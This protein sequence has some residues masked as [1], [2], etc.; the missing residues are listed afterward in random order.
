MKA[1]SKILAPKLFHE[2]TNYKAYEY[3]GAHREGKEYVFRVW[4]PNA[5][6]AFVTGLFNGWSEDDPMTRVDDKGIWEARIA[7]NRFGSGYAYEYKFKSPYGEVYKCDP[8]AFYSETY[9]KFSSRYFD[10]SGYKWKDAG[11]MKKRGER[12]TRERVMNSPMNIYEVH[13]ESWRKHPNGTFPSYTELA[14]E[15]APYVVQMGYTHISLMPICEYYS[16]GAIAYDT[17][18]YF[19]PT[20]RFGTPKDFMSFVDTMHNA[21]IGVILEWNC[22]FLPEE[23]H[24]ISKFDGGYV[25]EYDASKDK[26]DKSSGSCFNI[27]SPEVQSFLISGAVYWTSVYHIDG[28]KFDDISSMLSLD[29]SQEEILIDPNI[30]YGDRAPYEAAAFFRKLNRAMIAH[31][32]DV[33]MIAEDSEGK[34]EVTDFKNNGLGFSL[35]W[36]KLWADSVISYASLSPEWRG[37]AHDKITR[38]VHSSYAQRNIIPLSHMRV[39]FGNQSLVSKLPGSYDEKFAQ[40]RAFM[41]YFMTQPGKKLSFMG[42]EISQFD[43]WNPLGNIQWFLLDYE[44]H[45][46]YQLFCAKL[47][48]LYLETPALWEN[49][50]SWDGFR[51]IDHEDSEKSTLSYVRSDAEGNEI[52]CVF[53]FSG[54]DIEDYRLG[55]PAKGAYEEIF[56]SDDWHYGGHHRLSGKVKSEGVPQN[57]FEQSVK[58][59]LP[60]YSAAIFR[61]VDEKEK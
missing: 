11:W 49:D 51:W 9:P 2:G 30:I 54:E 28:I 33:L 53:N 41:T 50:G 35:K 46:R 14:E 18:G 55:V 61:R 48:N 4:A 45:A 17:T 1:Q 3:F 12:Y 20:S 43:E 40:M 34:I 21:G 38:N 25:Y 10:L 6:E 22:S 44:K 37:E 31:H 56:A 26:K 52:I 16:G 29:Y 7:Q 47:N 60:A 23:S 42:N 24:G 15:L 57:S 39:S 19:S 13:P 5:T 59:K 32:P 27:C 36:D 58:I 8:Y